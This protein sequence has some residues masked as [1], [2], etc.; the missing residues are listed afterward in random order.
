MFPR[1]VRRFFTGKPPPVY[2][3]VGT[4][5]V[6]G[7]DNVRTGSKS[8]VDLLAAQQRVLPHPYPRLSLT[9]VRRLGYGARE[10]CRNKVRQCHGKFRRLEASSV[11]TASSDEHCSIQ[12]IE[13]E[14]CL[15][16]LSVKAQMTSTAVPCRRTA[17][18]QSR[19]RR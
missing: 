15:L 14:I 2:S 11:S 3:R 7:T 10:I 16:N 18:P 4:I 13:A 5:A 9:Q 1:T 12:L 6:S 19:T 8:L 17:S